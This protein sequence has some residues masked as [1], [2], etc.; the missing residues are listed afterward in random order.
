MSEN[1]PLIDIHEGRK[2][3]YYFLAR[4]F[5][6]IPDEN[7]YEQI[8]S[9]LPAFNVI[10]DNNMMKE[11]CIGFEHF[12]KKREKTAGEERMLFDNDI[13]NDYSILFCH[14]DKI[15]LY[16]SDYTA[17]YNKSLK[18]ELAYLYKQYGYELEDNNYTDHI[19]YQ[20]SFMGYLAGITAININK[21]NHEMTAHLLDVQKE[22]LNTYMFSYIN[23]FFSSIAKIPES[24]LLYYACAAML[25][26]YTEYDYKFL[27][28]NINKGI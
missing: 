23:T 10:A 14:K 24:A 9:I 5:V 3:F 22:F 12:N 7:M 4:L 16:Q 1:T 20:L 13:L 27:S 15:N 26:G 8:T 17:P 25:L 6:D 19:S 21:A 18:D 28:S 11:G 2:H